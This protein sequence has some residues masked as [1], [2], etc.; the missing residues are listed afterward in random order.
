MLE[1]DDD[2]RD[3]IFF[4]VETEEITSTPGPSEAILWR[5]R[6]GCRVEGVGI[7]LNRLVFGDSGGV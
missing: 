2:D 3:C 5:S 4:S 7:A 1:I 6:W